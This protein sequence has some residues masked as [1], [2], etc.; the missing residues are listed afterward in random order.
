MVASSLDP[1]DKIQ[2]DNATA[3]M[4]DD[5]QSEADVVHGIEAKESPVE[6]RSSA[7][8]PVDA[9]ST[10][11]TTSAPSLSS[12]LVSGAASSGSMQSVFGP[13][14]KRA[15][16][17]RESTRSMEASLMKSAV[18]YLESR[19]HGKVQ[20][21]TS[22]VSSASVDEGSDAAMEYLFNLIRKTKGE[23]KAALLTA[24]AKMA[25]PDQRR[26]LS[27]FLM[28]SERSRCPD[29]E[30]VSDLKGVLKGM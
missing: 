20:S 22:L 19:Q 6:I 24:V 17:E 26:V 3:Q 7:F 5:E 9:V 25:N 8:V 16:K 27:Q 15:R 13:K 23:D 11:G 1:G 28:F 21:P 4:L 14:A 10:T 2:M 30:V 12:M 29:E 18:E